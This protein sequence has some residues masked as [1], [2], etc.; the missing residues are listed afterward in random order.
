ML[1]LL[2]L[3]AAQTQALRAPPTRPL[4]IT[5]VHRAVTA[6][7]TDA[8]ATV[9]TGKVR[10]TRFVRTSSGVG[11]VTARCLIRSGRVGGVRS[12]CV[13]TTCTRRRR[14]IVAA[15]VSGGCTLCS[16]R[17]CVQLRGSARSHSL[18]GA[19]DE[20]YLAQS[21]ERPVPKLPYP[22]CQRGLGL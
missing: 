20:F 22:K 9:R 11:V 8:A 14:N 4:W 1:R 7:T 15:A 16:G 19:T 3:L 5:H 21:S 12:A 13:V 18:S 6:P 17:V 10:A 2:L